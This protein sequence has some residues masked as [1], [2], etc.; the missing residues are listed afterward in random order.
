MSLSHTSPGDSRM[1][2]SGLSLILACCC[3]AVCATASAG[4]TIGEITAVTATQLKIKAS[5][6]GDIETYKLKSS[7][8][9]T[10]AGKVAAADALVVGMRVQ[11]FSLANGD[12]T[13]VAAYEASDAARSPAPASD[14]TPA[15]PTSPG[16]ASRPAPQTKP[17]RPA[18]QLSIDL[19]ATPDFP[20]FR[21]PLRDGR[22]S[23][24]GVLTTW[25]AE[26]PPLLNTI[27]GLGEGYGAPSI[28]AGRL[29]VLGTKINGEKLFAFDLVTG[30]PL[31]MVDHGAMFSEGQGNG[32]RSTPTY[33]DGKLYSLGASGDLTCV[34][35][36]TG[37]INWQKNLIS[38]YG[39]SI[40]TWGLAESPLIDGDNVIVTPGAPG[41]LMVALNR[42]TG[43]EVWKASIPQNPGP[44][45]ASAIVA[46]Y[47]GVRQYINFCAVG[48][49]G[50]RASDGTPLWGD[51]SSSNETANCSMPLALPTGVFSASGYN[52]GGSLVR[53]TQTGG[54]FTAKPLYLVNRMQNHHGGMV[55]LDGYIYGST[56]TPTLMCIDTRDGSIKWESREPGKGSIAAVDGRL[57]HRNEDGTVRIIKASSVEYVEELRFKPEESG[58]RPAWAYPVI[59]GGR[60]YLRDQDFVQ[61]YSLTGESPAPGGL[62]STIRNLITPFLPGSGPA[63]GP[64]GSPSAPTDPAAPGASVTP[65]AS[66]ASP[67]P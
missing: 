58:G 38:L 61:V 14:S 28:A 30:Q 60:L 44:A 21:G 8:P 59:A 55:A 48:L 26:G 23:G 63:G 65:D 52:K 2:R 7:T 13:K 16:A 1:W 53:L 62:T 20:Q 66:G 36:S 35:A 24:T 33:D 11:V 29:F 12:V 22:A 3:L 15:S 5:A 42:E 45:Y 17:S 64:G 32:P 6:T 9:I 50:V 49:F 51:Q 54:R 27:R 56:D 43:A 31:W 39:G 34:E 37:T 57:V 41:A 47:G 10:V 19:P 4:V 67:A 46:E 25:P 40:P 18:P